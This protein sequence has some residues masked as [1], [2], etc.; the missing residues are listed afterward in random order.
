MRLTEDV[1]R[2]DLRASIGIP[3]LASLALAFLLG[4]TGCGPRPT[5]KYLHA[6]YPIDTRWGY[7]GSQARIDVS[8]RVAASATAHVDEEDGTVR[9]TVTLTNVARSRIRLS[10]GGCPVQVQVFAAED[11]AGTPVWDSFAAERRVC[12]VV[13]V[14]LRLERSEDLYLPVA[15]Q[16]EAVLGDSL[17]GGRYY[18][19][20]VVRPNGIRMDLPA[21]G[22]W[23]ER[24]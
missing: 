17:P 24:H 4:T 10:M 15:F 14:P 18:V 6:D 20:A 11:Y 19:S 2:A 23:L 21:G 1:S 3:L 7:T 12:P 9:T 16:V 5:L 22:V 8:G 13:E